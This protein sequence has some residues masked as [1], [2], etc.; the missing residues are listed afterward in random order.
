[1]GEERSVAVSYRSEDQ[2]GMK[3]YVVETLK[4]CRVHLSCV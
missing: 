3:W 4:V 1:M 2:V